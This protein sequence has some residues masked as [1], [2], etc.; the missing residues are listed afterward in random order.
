[1]AV[2]SAPPL[3]GRLADNNATLLPLVL[4]AALAD[5]RAGR[6]PA[7]DRTAE[8]IVEIGSQSAGVSYGSDR[9]KLFCDRER[10]GLLKSGG[11]ALN[12]LS[13]DSVIPSEYGY[14]P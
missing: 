4:L 11:A 8:S 3:P 1:V 12:R 5:R 13:A 9:M 6:Q 14:G 10:S 2:S 7:P